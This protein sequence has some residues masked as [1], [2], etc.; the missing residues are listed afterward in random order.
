MSLIKFDSTKLTPFVHENELSEMQAM[1]NA[2]DSELKN[3]TGAGSDFLGWVNLPVDY[4]KDEF[5]RIKKAAKKIQSDS[6]VLVCIG[7][8]GSYLGAQAAI[9]FLNGA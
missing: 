7:I 8:G 6:E 5:A 2:A 1:V 3:G 4:D 9:E